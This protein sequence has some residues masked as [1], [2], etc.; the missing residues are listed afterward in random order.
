MK[1]IKDISGVL[2]WFSLKYGMSDVNKIPGLSGSLDDL[3]VK[4]H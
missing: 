3:L 1:Q 2:N 4:S